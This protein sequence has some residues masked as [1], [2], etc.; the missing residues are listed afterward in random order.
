MHNYH[1]AAEFSTEL[2]AFHPFYLQFHHHWYH[3]ANIF[4]NKWYSICRLSVYHPEADYQD[5]PEPESVEAASPSPG[6]LVLLSELVLLP[7]SA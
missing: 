1:P 3:L 5:Y 2:A 7:E 4:Q 6:K